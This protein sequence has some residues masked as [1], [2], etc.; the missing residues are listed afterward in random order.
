MKPFTEMTVKIIQ[1][2]P[3]GKV[4]TYGQVAA[5]AGSPRAA[6]Q[7]VRILH[8]MSGKYGLPWHRVLNSK[9]EIG[10]RD[11][12]QMMTQRLSLEAE[13][14]QFIGDNRVELGK[15]QYEPEAEEE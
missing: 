2:I 11:E 9:G 6:R 7:V 10:F 13:G 1:N 14:I 12:E 3:A 15:F 8:S 4:M 5:R